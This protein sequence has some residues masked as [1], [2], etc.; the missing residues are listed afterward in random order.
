MY[1]RSSWLC[2][3][4]HIRWSCSCA[5]GYTETQFDW[6]SF[7]GTPLKLKGTLFV[8]YF[9]LLETCGWLLLAW[10]ACWWWSKRSLTRAGLCNNSCWGWAI[11]RV[12][13]SAHLY[14]KRRCNSECNIFQGQEGSCPMSNIWNPRDPFGYIF[15]NFRGMQNQPNHWS[16]M[17]FAQCKQESLLGLFHLDSATW[18]CHPAPAQANYCHQP[19]QLWSILWWKGVSVCHSF[20][21]TLPEWPS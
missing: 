13:Q 16:W 3:Q 10:Q 19:T 17:F 4:E 2:S 14:P 21:Q 15:E 1:S 20:Q 12:R 5:K 18:S 8:D 6:C 7:S 11:P 9:R